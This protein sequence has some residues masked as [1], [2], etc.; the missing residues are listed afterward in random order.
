MVSCQRTPT[1]QCISIIINLQMALAV[2]QAQLADNACGSTNE[3]QTLGAAFELCRNEIPAMI[4]GWSATHPCGGSPDAVCPTCSNL[5]TC[6][7]SPKCQLRS[8]ATAIS[9]RD[10]ANQAATKTVTNVVISAKC[11]DPS[12]SKNV[13]VSKSS[14]AA[15]LVQF[16]TV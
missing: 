5:N 7:K 15:V 1:I 4:D 11:V 10:N 13:V 8:G 14:S 3:L 6:T 9:F 12:A 2:C 16:D